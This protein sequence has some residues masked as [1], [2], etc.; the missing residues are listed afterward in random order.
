M[1][2]ITDINRE[3]KCKISDTEVTGRIQVED[4]SIYLCQN[5]KNGFRCS[6]KLG[7]LYSWSVESGSDSE[8]FN[9]GIT[10]FI[11][12]DEL[13]SGWNESVVIINIITNEEGIIIFSKPPLII[14]KYRNNDNIYV[15]SRNYTIDELK[16][17]GWKIK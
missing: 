16:S 7:Y 5:E 1:I 13:S 12:L 11:F 6:N 15:A 8:L 9:N 3:F 2:K 4:N 17:E 14:Y 10:D